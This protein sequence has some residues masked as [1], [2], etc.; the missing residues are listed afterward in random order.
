MPAA[1]GGSGHGAQACATPRIAKLSVA[2]TVMATVG[3]PPA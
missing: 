1:L 2:R 3:G